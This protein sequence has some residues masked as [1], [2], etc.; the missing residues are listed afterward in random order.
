MG[1][2]SRSPSPR[3]PVRIRLGA[4]RSVRAAGAA[5]AGPRAPRRSR[6]FGLVLFL[7]G[8]LAGA[9]GTYLGCRQE[10][11][12]EPRTG[13]EASAPAAGPA[14][15]WPGRS[16]GQAHLA[17]RRQES[18]RSGETLPPAAVPS[19][20]G[21]PLDSPP[22][23][24][25][26]KRVALVID[27]L[28]RSLEEVEAL[29]RLGVP[30]TYAVLPFESRTQAVVAALR[31]HDEEILV[32]LPMEPQ[33]GGN[34]GPGALRLGMTGEQLREGTAAALDAVP[35]AVGANNH[36]GSGLSTDAASMGT[37]L[38]VL[39]RRNLFFLDSRTSAR[40]VGYQLALAM[41]LP[42]AERQVFLDD[43]RRPEAIH[44]QFEHLLQVADVR[45]EGIAIGHPHPE[46]LAALGQEVPRAKALGYR[47][48]LVSSLMRRER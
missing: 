43:D 3:K 21:G 5:R 46:T 8:A 38:E 18:P 12:P 35:G 48:V 15:R 6:W 33:G 14:A 11:A 2:P 27:D 17:P 4:D 7:L 32:H 28:G 25:A 34:P 16:N 19:P 29:E 20:G 41:G 31:R 1:R 26:G 42:A 24:Q 44:E 47:F 36:M 37:I 9:A 39:S 23:P 30:V 10:R 13:P 22:D 40:S 45:G